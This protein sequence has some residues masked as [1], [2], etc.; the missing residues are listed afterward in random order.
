[1][2]LLTT[3]LIFFS[4]LSLFFL[5]CQE[6]EVSPLHDLP[7]PNADD[8]PCEIAGTDCDGPK[9]GNNPGP[10]E[11]NETGRNTYV[12]GDGSPGNPRVYHAD[13]FYNESKN[14]ASAIA[15]SLGVGTG[16]YW[17]SGGYIDGVYYSSGYYYVGF[18]ASGHPGDDNSP[19][20]PDE[21]EEYL[22][23]DHQYQQ[24]KRLAQLDWIKKHGGREFADVIEAIFNSPSILNSLDLGDVY[25]LNHLVERV[26]LQL[27]AE[28]MMSIFSPEIVG[29]ILVFSLGVGVNKEVQNKFFKLIPRLAKAGNV[30]HI[31]TTIRKFKDRGIVRELPLRAEISQEVNLVIN[32]GSAK[33]NFRVE[34]QA[35]V[36]NGVPVRHANIEYWT[37]NN[38]YRW[39]R[40]YNK[41]VILE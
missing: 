26:Y 36:P 6:D 39:T 12:T 24:A 15:K 22:Q 28:Y 8:D 5:G 30:E 3:R 1:M 29:E 27:R 14:D 21:I 7:M 13:I 41:H 4:F 2:K 20:H 25:D 38:G 9:G 11:G 32:N 23:D 31:A 16:A 35:M 37:T 40:H 17:S 34:T 10:G 33:I 19:D 18:S